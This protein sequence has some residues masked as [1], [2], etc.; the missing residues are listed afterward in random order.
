M[1]FMSNFNSFANSW[2]FFVACSASL[3]LFGKRLVISAGPTYENIDPV[4]FI[5]NYSSGKMGFELAKAA[6]NLGAKV[7]LVA[8]P[9]HETVTGY[10]IERINVVSCIFYRKHISSSFLRNNG[11]HLSAIAP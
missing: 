10:P 3:P 5:G 11:N 8:G 2:A 6:S 4:R 7:T 9:S 1:K